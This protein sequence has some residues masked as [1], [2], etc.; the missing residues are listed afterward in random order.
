MSEVM[1]H[2]QQRVIDGEDEGLRISTSQPLCQWCQ[3]DKA[4]AKKLHME[5]KLEEL[6]FQKKFQKGQQSTSKKKKAEDQEEVG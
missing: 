3:R 5:M 1:N 2:L 4:K 6:R